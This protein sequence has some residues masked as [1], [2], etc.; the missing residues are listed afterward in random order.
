ME[1]VSG[2]N[3][4]QFFEQWL[5]KPGA[6]HLEVAWQYDESKKALRL[7]VKQTQNDGS[8]FVMPV[9]IVAL[10]ADGKKIYHVLNVESAEQ[11]FAFPVPFNPVSVVVDPDKWVLMDAVVINMK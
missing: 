11:D 5:Y 4:Q 6:L 8:L 2:K 3:L 1:S 9:Q 7:K 10:S